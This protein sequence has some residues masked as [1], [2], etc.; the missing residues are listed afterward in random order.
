MRTTKAFG[1]MSK[2]RLL[3]TPFMIGVIALASVAGYLGYTKVFA[4]QAD[5][6]STIQSAEVTL[7]NITASIT[8]SGSIKALVSSNLAFRTNG[9]V[10]DVYVKVGDKVIKGQPLAKLDSSS[11]ELAVRQAEASVASSQAKL[12]NIQRGAKPEDIQ[13]AELAIESA[14]QKLDQMKAGGKLQEIA[15]ATATLESAKANLDDALDGPSQS[16]LATAQ[17]ALDTAAANLR[18]AQA[19]LDQLISP[20]QSDI[21]VAKATL[22]S[23][24]ASLESAKAKLNQLTSPVPDDI[25]AAQYKVDSATASLKSAEAKLLSITAGPTQSELASAEAAVQVAAANLGEAKFTMD[26]LKQSLNE[27]RLKNL[28]DAYLRL[29]EARERLD[30]HKATGAPESQ[31]IADQ[32]ELLLALRRVESAE[33]DLDWTKQGVSA[34]DVMKAQADIDSATA[35]LASAKAKLDELRAGPKSQDVEQAQASVI[36]ARASLLTAQ[37]DLEKIKHPTTADLAAARS[38]VEQAQTNVVSAQAKLDELLNPSGLDLIVVQDSVK[39]AVSALNSAQIKFDEVSKGSTITAI[40]TAEE[41]VSQAQLQLDSKINP[42]TDFDLQNQINSATQAQL[43]LNLKA[44]P[45][46]AEDILSAQAGVLQA[47]V[48]LMQAKLNLQYATLIAPFDGIISAVNISA[49]SSSGSGATASSGSATSGAIS[50]VDP[51]AFAVD[52]NVD[53]SQV[54]QVSLGQ[55]ALMTLDALQDRRLTGSVTSVSPVS[56]VQSGVTTYLVS[57]SIDRGSVDVVKTGMTA[58]ANIVSSQSENVL[59]VPARAVKRQGRDQVVT[60]LVD[61]KQETKVV[62]TGITDGSRIEIV[63]GLSE[64]D[65]V[66][67]G[68]AGSGTT[69]APT[70]AGGFG[71]PGGGFGGAPPGG[72]GVGFGGGARR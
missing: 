40:K 53:E 29:R 23:S 6:A 70:V 49:G 71:G 25:S 42:Y 69:G 41:R 65:K 64:G 17:N 60:L 43:Q 22:E 62:K 20:Q 45:Y 32:E 63:E 33:N 27:V 46:A 54:A 55:R 44:N 1:V 38:Q 51:S 21:G 5:A 68:S 47:E 3:S 66:V 19:K 28:I 72:L 57:L 18:S 59:L 37:L 61:G 50:I 36:Q 16:E 52:I 31:L 13:I 35:N 7:G 10:D 9:W 2:K 67:V 58:Q 14:R 48:N 11:L 15:A 12:A 26:S 39:N 30:R 34:N 8:A 56:Q 4:K 24:K